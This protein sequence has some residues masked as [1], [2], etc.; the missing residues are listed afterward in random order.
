MASRW[1]S[2]KG[3]SRYKISDKGKIYDTKLDRYVSRTPNEDGYLKVTLRNDKNER[4]GFS[5]HRLV[6]LC[7]IKNLK[8]LPEVNHKDGIKSNC[9]YK[10]L[11]WC[12]HADNIQHTWDNGLLK[13]DEALSKRMSA[14][15]SLCKGKK[16]HK[17]IP[18]LCIT[19][20]EKFESVNLA[21]KVHKV[22]N[23]QITKC[24]RNE[25]KS[26]GKHPVTGKPL[27]WR[28]L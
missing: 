20:K 10:N 25:V 8:N 6:A 28:F 27:K 18:V 15:A 3:F 2:Y 24:C 14:I 13:N 9:K 12:T 26:A 23:T 17:S 16:N 4:K 7:F 5:V 11:E 1:K 19:T 21:T 22:S